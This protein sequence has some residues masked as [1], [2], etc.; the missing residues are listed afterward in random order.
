MQPPHKENPTTSLQH[1]LYSEIDRKECLTDT[2]VPI[3]W[4]CKL[5]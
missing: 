1:I 5:Y 4:M 2:H 3:A